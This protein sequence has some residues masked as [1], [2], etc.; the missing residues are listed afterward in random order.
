LYRERFRFES[1][2]LQDSIEP[3]G[4][5]RDDFGCVKPQIFTDKHGSFLIRVIREN[6]WLFLEVQLQAKLELPWVEG[7]GRTAEEASVARPQVE[8]VDVADKWG[9]G[10]FVEAVK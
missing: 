4:C 10:G 6:L 1:S 2:E 3:L 5:G 9:R 7:G 8:T